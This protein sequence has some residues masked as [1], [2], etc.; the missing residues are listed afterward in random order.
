LITGIG[1]STPCGTRNEIKKDTKN[2]EKSENCHN[3]EKSR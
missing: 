1:E 2:E 3:L